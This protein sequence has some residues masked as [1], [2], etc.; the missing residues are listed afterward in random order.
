MSDRKPMP[1]D[2]ENRMKGA[3]DGVNIA[4]PSG[5]G[6][7]GESGG[8]SYPNGRENSDDQAGGFSN[9]GGQ[10][11][12]GYH[13]GGQAG[14]DGSANANAATQGDDDFSDQGATGPKPG[15]RGPDQNDDGSRTRTVVMQGRT[16]SVRDMSGIAAAE[17]SGQTGVKGQHA[18]D[19]EAPGAG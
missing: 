18:S 5:R 1:A 16:V 13:G 19:E 7:Q 17:A 11:N 9:H 10:S 12:I 8:G 3:P 4:N 6:D 14:Q 2:G 15:P